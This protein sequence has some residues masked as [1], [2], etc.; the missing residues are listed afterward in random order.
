MTR[1][2]WLARISEAGKHL[3]SG[4]LSMEEFEALQ[5]QF[6]NTLT[7]LEMVT[8]RIVRELTLLIIRQRNLHG[9]EEI[10]AAGR[11]VSEAVAALIEKLFGDVRVDA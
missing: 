6:E 10:P 9:N 1:T 5:D 8:L 11:E 7:E 3:A 2:E 4:D